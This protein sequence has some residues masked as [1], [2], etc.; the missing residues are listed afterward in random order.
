MSEMPHCAAIRGG[1]KMGSPQPLPRIREINQFLRIPSTKLTESNGRG[2]GLIKTRSFA[3][4][5][6]LKMQEKVSGC[7]IEVFKCIQ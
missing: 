2:L 5:T 3:P 1:C 7:T 4:G 6:A